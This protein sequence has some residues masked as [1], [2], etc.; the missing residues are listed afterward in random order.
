MKKSSFSLYIKF[1]HR[2]ILKIFTTWFLC[3]ALFLFP[4]LYLRWLHKCSLSYCQKNGNFPCCAILIISNKFILFS[5]IFA[6]LAYYSH[7][8]KLSLLL[9]FRDEIIFRLI[10]LVLTCL[11][12]FSYS[13]QCSSLQFRGSS[14]RLGLGFLFFPRCP[15][16]STLS[17]SYRS[18]LKLTTPWDI[19]LSIFSRTASNCLTC[20]FKVM[21]PS[22][23]AN[24]T[25]L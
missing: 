21:V 8:V 9:P 16:S 24:Y 3:W 22:L 18:D 1:K 15:R 19:L 20:D 5:K 11:S 14:F 10:M 13:G 2:Y 12:Y 17:T 4:V 6:I 7:C 23:T 25:P